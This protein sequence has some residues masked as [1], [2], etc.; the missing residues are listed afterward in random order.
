MV[1]KLN[2]FLI[3]ALCESI[4]KDYLKGMC[5]KSYKT[6]SA[7]LVEANV[8]DPNLKDDLDWVWDTRNRMHLFSLNDPEYNNDYN[9]ASHNRCVKTFQGLLAALEARGRLGPTHRAA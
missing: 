8:I 1:Y 4:T 6:R 9:V 2:M 5:G 3:G 7:Y